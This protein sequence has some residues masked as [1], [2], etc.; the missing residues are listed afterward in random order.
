MT[1]A[2]QGF[3]Q[4]SVSEEDEFL[5]G[6]KRLWHRTNGDIGAVFE[7][8]DAARK[9]VRVVRKSSIEPHKSPTME[10]L[11]LV[12]RSTGCTAEITADCF[13]RNR[14]DWMIRRDSDLTAEYEDNDK[15]TEAVKKRIDEIMTL[16]AALQKELE[17]VNSENGLLRAK[18][19][20]AITKGL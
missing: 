12:D 3:E 2:N 15:T 19:A 4:L 6:G 1:D 8:I 20:G 14:Y 17:L 16:R 11:Q 13:R 18:F 5:L 10:V 9:I 7:F